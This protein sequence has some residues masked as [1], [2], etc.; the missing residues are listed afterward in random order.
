MPPEPSPE[1]D[2]Q[3]MH[4]A[5]ELAARGRGWVE[6]N[7]L[8]G[9]VIVRDGKIV[10]EG[11]HQR[12]GGPHAEVEALRVAGEAARG[13]TLYVTLE[14]CCHF[15]KTPPCTQAVVKAGVA[16]V[17]AAM[18]DPFPQVSGQGAAELQQA[19]VQIDLG[20]LAAE[21][22]ELNAPYL[23]L[24]TS[25][26]PW[27][28]AK[29]AMTLDGKIATRTGASKW[30]S[31]PESRE[32][33]QQLRGR[34]DGI[35]IGRRTAELD[36]P[37]LTARIASGEKPPRVATRIVLDSQASL[38]LQSQLVQT[39][40]EVPL[41]VVA[42]NTA[43]AANVAALQKTG[44]EVL[45]LPGKTPDERL[46]QLLAELGSRRLTNVLCEGGGQ[47]LGSLFD[48][49]LVDEVHCFIAPKIF[50][51]AQAAGPIA[52]AGVELPSLATT[53]SKPN[54][55]QVG[56]DLYVRGRVKTQA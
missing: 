55:Q 49:S 43:S 32:L 37:L 8:V 27:L 29:W 34:V 46:T 38:N 9:C 15:G 44:V 50:G 47:L 6:P 26:Q 13:S 22:H 25:G 56:D 53:L 41:L 4:R 1:Q 35:L 19:G 51:G 28:I 10:G 39:A 14:P 16:R 12:Y 3:F 40:R 11:F 24:L 33:V 17:V 20:L 52:G 54:W 45:Q 31:G 30:I 7:P 2:R 23:K 21:A 18:R 48:A 36:D 5:L 42:A